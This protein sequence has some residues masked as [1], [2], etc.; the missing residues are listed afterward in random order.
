MNVMTMTTM[1]TINSKWKS[2]VEN[3]VY[4]KSKNKSPV[5]NKIN[6]KNNPLSLRQTRLPQ[7]TKSN[8]QRKLLSKR[9]IQKRNSRMIP[10]Q[11]LRARTTPR[12]I[13]MIQ[14]ANNNRK[15]KLAS[16]SF[17]NKCSNKSSKLQILISPYLFPIV[18]T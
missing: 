8:L 5:K 4:N 13:R 12:M 7:W 15:V 3:N 17:W 10:K 14:A 2:K 11:I 6:C 1:I 18:K 16:E 9:M